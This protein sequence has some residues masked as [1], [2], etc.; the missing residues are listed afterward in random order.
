[1]FSEHEVHTYLL[2]PESTEPGTVPACTKMLDEQMKE[3][4]CS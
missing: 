1:M 2:S 4:D 3:T